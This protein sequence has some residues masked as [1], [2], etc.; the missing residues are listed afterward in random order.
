MRK[1]R[2]P[3]SDVRNHGEKKAVIG[4]KQKRGFHL[5]AKNVSNTEMLNDNQETKLKQF[6]MT[7]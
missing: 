1:L 2:I 6:I 3:K 7:R 4:T 5:D